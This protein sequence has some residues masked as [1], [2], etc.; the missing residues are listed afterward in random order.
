MVH[1]PIISTKFIIY[2]TKAK[3][4]TRK[5]RTTIVFFF[6]LPPMGERRKGGGGG[7]AL[8]LRGRAGEI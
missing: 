2:G 1:L 3:N 6:A 7:G 4:F 8:K 5:I